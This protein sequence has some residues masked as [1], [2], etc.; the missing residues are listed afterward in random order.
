MY[1]YELIVAWSDEDRCFIVAVPELPG[2]TAHGDTPAAAVAEAQEA[3]ALWIE[4]AGD[5]GLPV[6]SPR[7]GTF[8]TRLSPSR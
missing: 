5:D 4:T 1:H 2:C 8:N 6:P 7:V 3:I